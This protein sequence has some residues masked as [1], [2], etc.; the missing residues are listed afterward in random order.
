MNRR[1]RR[2]ILTAIGETGP[3]RR[4]L[5]WAAHLLFDLMGVGAGLIV[6]AV[7]AILALAVVVVVWS[8][9][10]GQA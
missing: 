10:T 8:V 7:F 4:S 6:V 1:R 2:W 9:A 5:P 3:R